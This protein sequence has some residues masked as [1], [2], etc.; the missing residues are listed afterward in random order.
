MS[1]RVRRF[2]CMNPVKALAPLFGQAEYG[3]N[4]DPV[5]AWTRATS[6]PLDRERRIVGRGVRDLLGAIFAAMGTDWDEVWLPDDVYPVY[7]QLASAAGKLASGYSTLP[8]LESFFDKTSKRAA[9]VLPIP[10]SPLGRLPNTGERDAIIGWLEASS[11]RL[12]I[13]DAV[14]TYEFAAS[15][16]FIHTLMSEFSEQCVI[17]WSCAKSWLAPGALGIGLLPTR[18]LRQVQ[19]VTESAPSGSQS[20]RIDASLPLRQQ[21][22][23]QREWARIAC[24]LQRADPAWQPPETGYFS[25]LK[26]PFARMLDEHNIL[27]VPASVFGSKRDDLS[28]VTCLHD[29]AEH[30]EQA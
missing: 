12:L 27:S 15:N 5:D 11:E 20:L 2:D 9:A 24:D 25:I 14:Y 6:I 22:A 26:I 21:G 30:E 18:I 16:S 8:L 23:F 7:W 13:V 1:P 4:A 29:L 10:L 28:V 19:T 3:A 17:L